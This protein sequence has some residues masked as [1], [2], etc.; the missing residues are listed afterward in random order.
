MFQ[1]TA[2]R[3]K[4]KYGSCGL[5]GFDTSTGQMAMEGVEIGGY[6]P[7][8]PTGGGVEIG[9]YVPVGPTGGAVTGWDVVVT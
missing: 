2:S 8:G 6:V 4:I 7:V 3:K 1:A 9:G 5:I